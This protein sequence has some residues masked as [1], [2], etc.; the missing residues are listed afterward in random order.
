MGH[1]TNTEHWGTLCYMKAS[2]SQGNRF[3]MILCIGDVRCLEGLKPKPPGILV[4]VSKTV[5]KHNE[6]K[7][8]YVV[9]LSHHSPSSEEVRKVMQAREEPGGRSSS[10]AIEGCCLLACSSCLLILLSSST[11]DHQPTL[12]PLTMG[13]VLLY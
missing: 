12:V 3:Y 2:Q 4:R 11:Q 7:R 6:G 10:K 9:I 8:I 1:K 13:W 5:I